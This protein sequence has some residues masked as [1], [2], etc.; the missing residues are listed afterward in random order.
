MK[1]PEAKGFESEEEKRKRDG[2]LL[3][4]PPQSG[5][6]PVKKPGKPIKNG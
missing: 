5:T 4:N 2:S 6:K 3:P 1:S